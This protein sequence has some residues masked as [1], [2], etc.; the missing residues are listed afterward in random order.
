MNLSTTIF[1]GSLVYYLYNR[2]YIEDPLMI[3]LSFQ[4]TV[5]LA[6]LNLINRR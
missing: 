3:N 4:T 1:Y 6:L 5:I 2:V